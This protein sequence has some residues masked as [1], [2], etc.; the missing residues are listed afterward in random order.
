MISV[1]E[2]FFTDELSALQDD[3]NVPNASLKMYAN[4]IQKASEVKMKYSKGRRIY[5]I[6]SA[7]VLLAVLITIFVLSAQNGE[8]SSSTS[9][10][11]TRLIEAIFGQAA[12]E[13]ILRTFAHFCEF[14]GLGFLMCNFLFA[15][16]DKLKPFWSF[17][18][19]FVYAI[20]D[21]IHQIFV[22]ERAFQVSDILVDSTGALIGVT[23]SFVILNF[24]LYTKKRRNKNGNS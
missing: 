3:Q 12:S 13:A 16:K 15:L 23:A 18:F 10:F 24:L 17:L 19:S 11:F 5:I 9:G 7:I 2:L 6:A 8:E 14:A 21:E 1:T 4:I 22:P 20:T